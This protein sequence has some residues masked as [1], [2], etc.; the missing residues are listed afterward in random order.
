MGNYKEQWKNYFEGGIEMWSY[1]GYKYHSYVIVK[2]ILP[3]IDIPKEG[4]LIQLGSGLG[5]TVELLCHMYGKERVVGYDLFNPLGHPNIKFLDTTKTTPSDRNIA[6]IE[7]DIS[8][9]SDAKK[10]RKELLKWAMDNVQPGGYILTNKSLAE[11]LKSMHWNFDI[12]YLNEFDI[13]ELW[14]NPH[15]NRINTKVLLQMKVQG[16]DPYLQTR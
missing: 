12:I 9:M 5:V 8:S 14:N 7:I 2:N 16:V 13:A 3:L 11:E 10:H 6:F 4:K 1:F 15:E